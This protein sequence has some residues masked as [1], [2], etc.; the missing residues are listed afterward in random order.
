[1]EKLLNNNWIIAGIIGD[2][3]GQV[4]IHLAIKMVLWWVRCLH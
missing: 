3:P 2:L 1:M 4:S